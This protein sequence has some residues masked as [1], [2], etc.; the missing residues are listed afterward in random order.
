MIYD[1]A[2]LHNV[3]AT[4]KRTDGVLLERVPTDARQELNDKARANYMRP[5]GCEVRAVSGEKTVSVTLSCPDGECEATPYY[6]PFLSDPDE[7][8][9]IGPE[10]MTIDLV[11]PDRLTALDPDRVDEMAFSPSVRR[12]VL[13]GNPTVLH[14]VD[15]NVRPPKPGEIPGRRYLAYGTSITQGAVAS[16]HHLTYAAKTARRLDADLLNLGTGGS[17]FCE[18]AIADHIADRDDWDVAT[19]SISVNMIAAGFTPDEFRERA[20]YMIETIA[21]ANP[22]EPIVA[23]TLFPVFPD[24]GASCEEWAADPETYREVLRGVVS[25][26]NHGNIFLLEGPNLLSDITGLS[27]DLVHPSDDGMDEIA[28]RLVPRLSALLNR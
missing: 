16:R 23:I 8:V 13:R 21:D 20:T 18:P 26:S 1:G 2:E 5:S 25:A 15:G 28:R 14:S 17:A 12:L 22:D 27:P 4:A 3:A 24:L 10:P 7:W 19:L 9:R 6:G 11:V